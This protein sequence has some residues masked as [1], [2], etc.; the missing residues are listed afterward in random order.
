[1]STEKSVWAVVY[2][3]QQNDQQDDQQKSYH[4]SIITQISI[5]QNLNL[6]QFYRCTHL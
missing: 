2:F 5:F 1:M 6:I 4:V 3:D